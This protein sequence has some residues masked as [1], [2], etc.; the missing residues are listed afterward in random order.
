MPNRQFELLLDEQLLRRLR[1]RAA[2]LDETLEEVALRELRTWVGD[3]GLYARVYIVQPGDTLGALAARF[4]GDAS[5]AAVIAAFNGITN[6]DALRVGQTVRIPSAR[7]VEPP[8]PGESPFVFGMHDRG[9]EHLMQ[10]AGKPGWVLVTEEVGC[11]PSDWGSRS[12][13]DLNDKKHGI[14]VRL[15]HGY[16]D[17]GTLPRS[18]R[19]ADFARRC[20]NFVE[21]SKGCHVWIIGNETNLAVERPGGPAHGEIIT[22]ERYVKA[23][24]LCREEI[25]SRPGHAEDHVIPGAVGPWNVQTQYAGNPTGDWIIYFTDI[26]EAL[27]GQLDGIAI[28]TYGRSPD[29]REIVSER[30]MDPPFEHRRK[31]FRTYIDFMEA[32]PTGLWHLPV[33]ITETDQNVPWLDL[34][35]GW[36]QEAYAEINRWNSNP[37]H[38]KVRALILYRWEKH[39]GDVWAI[40]DK[41]GVI[42]DWRAAMQH[43]YRWWG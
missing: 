6:P 28:H 17:K 16:H 11:D 39:T 3:W 23:F 10:W 29:P 38:Q 34:N 26:L 4:Y 14:I 19:Y 37:V 40:Q 42:N 27:D 2:D 32:I 31:M 41:M 30:R 1:A 12:Y 43:E 15:N 20:G 7:P 33:Y 24:R 36:I 13:Q 22:P 21:R 25:R 18:N 5:K 8:P 35:N 9:A